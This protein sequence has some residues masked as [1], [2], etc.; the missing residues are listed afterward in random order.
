MIRTVWLALVC[1]IAVGALAALKAGVA[2]PAKQQA[3]LSANV[4]GTAAEALPKADRLGV[5]LRDNVPENQTVKTTT[6]ILPKTPTDDAGPNQPTKI[7]KIISRHWHE[8]STKM[9]KRPARSASHAEAS[10]K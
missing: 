8:G 4:I 2:T 9:T 3:E 5:S 6:I 7:N 1:L 10:A